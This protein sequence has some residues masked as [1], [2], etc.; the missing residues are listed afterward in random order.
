MESISLIS[1]EGRQEKTSENVADAKNNEIS[2]PA[3]QNLKEDVR[4]SISKPVEISEYSSGSDVGQLGHIESEGG[5]ST[6]QLVAGQVR[7]SS[8][9][10][11]T[12]K[13]VQCEIGKPSVKEQG[14]QSDCRIS[15]E[16]WK[17]SGTQTEE[18]VSCDK[19]TQW[20][21][22][23]SQRLAGRS[24]P[25]SGNYEEMPVE[26]KRDGMQRRDD[27]MKTEED[28]SSKGIV[29]N[30]NSEKGVRIAHSGLVSS[31]ASRGSQ[32]SPDTDRAITTGGLTREVDESSTVQK[33]PL[34]MNNGQQSALETKVILDKPQEKCLESVEIDVIELI[35]GASAS[36]SDVGSDEEVAERNDNQM[37]PG[38]ATREDDERCKSQVADNPETEDSTLSDSVNLFSAE[39]SYSDTFDSCKSV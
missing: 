4:N 7:V 37:A 39:S 2:R 21:G 20:D 38:E 16:S 19:G 11:L 30:N 8:G 14:T 36:L 12:Q 13:G 33:G 34:E 9:H 15:I 35:G 24:N 6:E 29:S 10:G 3:D 26:N 23:E 25:L 32:I 27:R 1:P 31:T 5:Q 22:R 18:T 28:G 17:D